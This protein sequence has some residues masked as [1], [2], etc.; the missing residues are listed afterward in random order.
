MFAVHPG[1]IVFSKIDARNGAIGILP[2][3]ISKAVVTP[4]FPVFI[5]H[6]DRLDGEFVKLVLRTG[7]FLAD[8][9]RKASGTSGRKRITPEAFLDLR[10]P[11]PSL[12]EQQSIVASYRTTLRRAEELE[13]EAEEIETKSVEAFETALGFD[14]PKPLSDRPVFVASFK[15]LDRWSHETVLRRITRGKTSTPRWPVVR[16]SEVIADLVVGWSPKCLNRPANEDEWAVLKLSAVTSGSL[17]PSENK[18]LPS[19]LAPRPD[20]EIKKGDV[21]ITRGSGVT[22]LVGATA[23]VEKTPP[24]RLMICDLIFRVIF[25][26]NGPLE[27]A[28]LAAILGI[29]TLREQIE[30]RRTGAAPMMQKITKSSLNA[31]TF[32]LPPLDTQREF[33]AVLHSARHGA[34]C[35]R[36]EAVRARATAWTDFEAAVYAGSRSN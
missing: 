16:L 2:S 30:G 32:P 4:E 6:P 3:E 5:P 11:L 9:R 33:A 1:D 26:E 7:G 22:R 34:Y 10:I 23:F 15:D 24:T 27:P 8:L 21:L 28:Y 17:A 13:R 19:N 25:N 29:S 35:L 36:D 31:L 20:L 14:P 12:T 18:A